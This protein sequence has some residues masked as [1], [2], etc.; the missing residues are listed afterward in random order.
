MKD[1]ERNNEAFKA[2]SLVSRRIAELEVE[3][4]RIKA[5]NAKLRGL[6]RD[7]ERCTMHADCDKCE[8]DGK[9]S[10]HCPM[11]P[12]FPDSDELRELGVEVP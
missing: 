2:L 8:Y 11:S 10:T 7:Y 1:I 6:V 5:E 12:C 9:M 3:T 4:E